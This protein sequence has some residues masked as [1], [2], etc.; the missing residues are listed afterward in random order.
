L[1]LAVSLGVATW[2]AGFDIFYALPDRV[3]DQSAG[4]RSV[5]VRLGIPRSIT[6]AKLLH[7]V[8]IPAL[9]VFGFAAG[10]GLWYYLG[11]IAA[12]GILAYEHQLVRPDDLSRLDAAFFSMNAIMSVTVFAFA[13]ADRLL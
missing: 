8:T 5:V 10:F 12:T 2:V 13:L 9:I 11:L 6:V 4:L 1:L 7:G 3:F